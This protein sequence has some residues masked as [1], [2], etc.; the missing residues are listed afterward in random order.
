MNALTIIISLIV[1]SLINLIKTEDNNVCPTF[2]DYYTM[3]S[4]PKCWYDVAAHLRLVRIVFS[5]HY[6]NIAHAI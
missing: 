3:K 6:F 4:N 5:F 2:K 1:I